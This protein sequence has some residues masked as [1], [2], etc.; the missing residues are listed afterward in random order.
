MISLRADTYI[1]GGQMSIWGHLGSQGSNLDFQKKCYNLFKLHSMTIRLI[2]VHQIET[3]YLRCGIIF[4][5]GVIW[6]HWGQK[7][8]FT[9]N[10][11][12]HPC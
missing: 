9:K 11:V 1:M 5:S 3:V 4:Q 7:V 2:H 10:V 12:T 8:I 6:G